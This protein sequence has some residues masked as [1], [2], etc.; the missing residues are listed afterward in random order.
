MHRV[1]SRRFTGEGQRPRVNASVDLVACLQELAGLRPAFHSEADFQLAL[2]WTIQTRHPSAR[3]RLEQRVLDQP[4]IELDILVMLDGLRMATELKYLRARLDATVDT[5]RFTLSLGA[6]DLERYDTIK[7]ITR[8]ERLLAEDVIDAGAVI[9]LSN[10]PAF[11]SRSSSGKPTGY[12]Q[13][14]LHDG[15]TL[16]GTVDWGASAG[17]GTR[18]NREVA[19]TLRGTYPLRWWPYSRVAESSGGEFRALIVQVEAG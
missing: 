6:P 7:D 14:R 2:A 4:R 13:F 1:A 15:T 3:I 5:E 11:W 19:H 17:P 18:R 8:I 12:D 16:T 9:A 10:N